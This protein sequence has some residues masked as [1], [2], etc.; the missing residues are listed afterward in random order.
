[1]FHNQHDTDDFWRGQ[2]IGSTYTELYLSLGSQQRLFSEEI[3]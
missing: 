3:L 1:M 2:A